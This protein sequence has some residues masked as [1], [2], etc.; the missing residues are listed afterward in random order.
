[1]FSS[2]ETPFKPP[3]VVECTLQENCLGF[4]KKLHVLDKICA[5]CLKRHD[6]QQ[7]REWVA[8]NASALSLIE[9]ESSRKQQVKRNIEARGRYL[10]AFEDPDYE[11][12]RWRRPDLNLRGTRADCG[13]VKRKGSACEKCWRHYLHKI[14]IVQYFTPLGRCHEEADKAAPEAQEVEATDEE[15]D[16][17]PEDRDT[18]FLS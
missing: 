12:C 5:D 7:L 1:M 16:E 9:E 4:G 15:E 17:E 3:P 14:D 11:H 18:S 6:P 10:C 8:H 13:V 2:S